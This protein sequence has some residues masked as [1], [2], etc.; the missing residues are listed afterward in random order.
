M[1]DTEDAA[2]RKTRFSLSQETIAIAT[3]SIALAGLITITTGRISDRLDRHISEIR[4][5]T[6][7]MQAEA[8]RSREEFRAREAAAWKEWRARE[9][10]SRKEFQAT[11]ARFREEYLA[12]QA[13]AREDR[14]AIQAEGRRDRMAIQAEGRRDRM[15]LRAEGREDRKAFSEQM[16]RIAERQH[17]LEGQVGV[18]QD[19]VRAADRSA[20]NPER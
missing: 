4:S 12:M 16:S 8:H 18:L 11:L 20:G 2:V 13:Q 15:A 9:A 6:A 7:A 5:D 3:F 10:E 1:T 14:L 19:S 17:F